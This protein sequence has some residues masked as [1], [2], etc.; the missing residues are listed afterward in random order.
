MD[1]CL[2]GHL[3]AFRLILEKKAGL[4]SRISGSILRI[5]KKASKVNPKYKK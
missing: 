1:C 5:Y 4:K 3:R 2:K